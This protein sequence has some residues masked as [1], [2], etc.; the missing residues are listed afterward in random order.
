MAMIRIGDGVTCDLS[1]ALAVLA[2][3][4]QV[5]RGA[6]A[7]GMNKTELSRASGLART[8]IIR[9]ARGTR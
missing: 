9:I 3:R 8:T 2:H 1:I 4:D 5:V 7:A 6:L